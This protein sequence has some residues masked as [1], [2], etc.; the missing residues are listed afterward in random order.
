VSGQILTGTNVTN[1]NTFTNPNNIR[2]VAFNDAKKDGSNISV[3]LP[4]H[5]VVSLEL[6]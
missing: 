3:K 6:K 5:S 1:I 4:A 2:L